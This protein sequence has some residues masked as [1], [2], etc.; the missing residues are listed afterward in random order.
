M[1]HAALQRNVSPSKLSS[2]VQH[3]F[4]DYQLAK[5]LVDNK[6]YW[7]EKYGEDDYKKEITN[8]LVVDAYKRGSPKGG[9]LNLLK[10]FDKIDTNDLSE[11]LKNTL[12]K[13]PKSASKVKNF[14]DLDEVKKITGMP[15][16]QKLR[17]SK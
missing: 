14:L 11:R 10:D 15:E 16:S 4:I 13:E 12:D 17:G 9:L 8:Y 5:S 3:G 6:D 1:I 2:I 7:I